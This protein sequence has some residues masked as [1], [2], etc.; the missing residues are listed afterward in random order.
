MKAT[1]DKAGRVVIPKVIRDQVGIQPGAVDIRVEGAGI[2]IQPVA[3]DTVTEQRGRLVIPASG[4]LLT[5]EVVRALRD[6]GQR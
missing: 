1:I 5:D 2:R 3:D 6:A 4:N